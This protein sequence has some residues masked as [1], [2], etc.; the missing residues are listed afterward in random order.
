MGRIL[1]VDDEPHMRRVLASA[2][3]LDRHV[4]S[5]VGGVTEARAQLSAGDFDAV[6]TD[7]KMGDGEGLDV[8]AAVRELDPTL[9]VVFITAFATIELAVES[10]RQG[11][12]DFVTKPFQPQVIR[13]TA[14]RACERTS[15]LRWPGRLTA[16]PSR[17]LMATK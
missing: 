14:K 6:F 8:L 11:A 17:R 15:L 4:T 3:A 13:A 7:Q 16:K 2:L 12:F 5:E 9:S 10:M 1:I